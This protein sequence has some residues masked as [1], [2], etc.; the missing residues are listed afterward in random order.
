LPGLYNLIKPYK[1]PTFRLTP[2][3]GAREGEWSFPVR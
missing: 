1:N 2:Y 3:A